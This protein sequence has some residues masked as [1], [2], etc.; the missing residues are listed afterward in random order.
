MKLS[1]F[2]LVALH[3]SKDALSWSIR[4]PAQQEVE[5]GQFVKV[6]SQQGFAI[7][8]HGAVGLVC[9]L[10]KSFILHLPSIKEGGVE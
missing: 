8:G 1:F 4:L 3:L 10:D 2:F 9:Q 6:K 5:E 7:A